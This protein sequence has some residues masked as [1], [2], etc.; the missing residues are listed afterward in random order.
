MCPACWAVVAMVTA[1]AASTGALGVLGV[2]VA[3]AVSAGRQA[4]LQIGPILNQANLDQ[5][6]SVERRDHDEHGD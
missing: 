4:N 6:N 3:R 5:T 2:K 1:G